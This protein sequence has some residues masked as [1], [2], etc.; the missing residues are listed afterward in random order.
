MK[1][2][3]NITY[4]NTYIP[5]ARRTYTDAYVLETTSTRV[6][7]EDLEDLVNGIIEDYEGR[8][9]WIVYTISS[10]RNKTLYTRA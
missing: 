9:G 7:K 3:Y 8:L 1:K 10:A 5:N 2:T 4:G 6:T